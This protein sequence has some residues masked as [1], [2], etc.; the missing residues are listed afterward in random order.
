M[1][2]LTDALHGRVRRLNRRILEEHAAELKHAHTVFLAVQVVAQNVDKAA[3]QLRTHHGELRGDRVQQ[4]DRGSFAAE[5]LLPLLF[6]KREVHEFLIA[7][8]G[9]LQTQVMLRAAILAGRQHHSALKRRIFRQLVVTPETGHF[10]HEVLFDFDIEA[11]RGRG[12]REEV[13]VTR[14]LKP[15]TLEGFFHE[16]GRNVHTDELAAACSAELHD[17]ALREIGLN[18]AH[19]ADARGVGSADRENERRDVLEM[20]TGRSI[21]DTALETERGV[22]REVELTGAALDRGRT[23]ERGLDEEVHRVIRHRVRRAAHDAGDRLRTVIIRDHAVVRGQVN[24][25]AVQELNLLAFLRP[26]RRHGAGELIEVKEVSRTAELEEHVIRNIDE[27]RNRTLTAAL[28]PLRH[29]FRRLRLGVQPRDHAARITGAKVRGLNLHG[30]SRVSRHSGFMDFRELQLSPRHGVDFTRDTGERKRVTAVRRDVQIHHDVVEVSVL[31]D[32]FADRGVFRQKPETVMILGHAELTGRAEHAVRGH[33]AQLRLLDLEPAGE[34]SSHHRAGHTHPS[35]DVRRAAD[36]LDQFASAGVHLADMQV[37]GI[38]MVAAFNDFSNH[39]TREIGGRLTGFVHFEAVH[40]ERVLELLA[41]NRGIHIR[42]KPAFRKQHFSSPLLVELAKEPEVA[43][44]EEPQVVDAVAQH[45]ETLKTRAESEAAVLLGIEPVVADHG[46][47][48]FAGAGNLK[49][50]ALAGAGG[51]HHVHFNRRLGER[52]V[53]RT[54]AHDEV[55]GF[56]EPAQEHGVH[57]LQIREADVFAEPQSFDLMEHRGVRGVGVNA[58][59]TSRSNHLDRRLVG[60]GVTDLHRGGVRAQRQ[61]QP[62]LILHVDVERILHRAGRMVEGVI[63]RRER[64]PVVLDFGAG[65]HVETDRTENLF[66]THPGA[67]HGVDAAGGRRTS[68]QRHID[69]FLGKLLLESGLRERFAA[70]VQRLFHSTLRG[71]DLSTGRL[72]LVGCEIPQTLH[73]CREGAGLPK[74]FRLGIFQR[75]RLR[76]FSESLPGGFNQFG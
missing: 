38:L 22:R 18:V 57:A 3:D 42:T 40:R 9:K 46:R 64:V 72:P 50:L 73:H 17:A 63:E 8:A 33:A 25:L 53:A 36:D 62:L 27:S 55:V 12:H 34:L 11:V 61:Q 19:R 66:N 60:A 49:P 5:I 58:V 75:C 74:E 37:I 23:E 21:V 52:E 16:V 32:I 4:T 65:G 28:K 43:F 35:S 2:G 13:T 67:D 29:P 7:A 56:E 54:K 20:L 48:H 1:L 70:G 59:G 41:R 10:F 6:D 39:D 71:I 76:R 31:A 24:G 44:K 47:V 26:A 45:R 51:E 14:V 68:R 30:M 69:R 15:E